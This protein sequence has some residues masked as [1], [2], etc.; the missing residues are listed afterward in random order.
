[1]P[2]TLFFILFK[3]VLRTLLRHWTHPWVLLHPLLLK[4][5]QI[6]T[7]MRLNLPGFAYR[8]NYS[9]WKV[10]HGGTRHPFCFFLHATW[11]K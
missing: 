7:Q 8:V 4:R 3:C 1:M 6:N 9:D 10:W 11:D 2:I 5:Q